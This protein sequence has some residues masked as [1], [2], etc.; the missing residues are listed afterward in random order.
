MVRRNSFEN[1]KNSTW[2]I[3]EKNVPQ[4]GGNLVGA[5]WNLEYIVELP[6]STRV[7][8]DYYIIPHFNILNKYYDIHKP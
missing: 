8:P 1:K 4:S 6:D 5:G 7:M 3:Y 2:P